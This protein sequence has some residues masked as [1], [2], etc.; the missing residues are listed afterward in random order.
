MASST[1]SMM[2]TWGAS[3][4]FYRVI[5]GLLFHAIS[6]VAGNQ[7]H[8]PVGP[9]VFIEASHHLGG[10]GHSACGRW[11]RESPDRP[12]GSHPATSLC[13]ARHGRP[14]VHG[15]GVEQH[16]SVRHAAEP[17]ADTWQNCRRNT[18]GAALVQGNGE[19]CQI[20]NRSN[21]CS[22]R[23][24][25]VALSNDGE[26]QSDSAPRSGLL[27]ATR[28]DSFGSRVTTTSDS[29]CSAGGALG[30]LSADPQRR[31]TMAIAV[32]WLDA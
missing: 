12:I 32:V 3:H 31:P 20:W 27:R 5:C 6:L 30:S 17:T 18:W 11:R 1:S 21:S 13:R 19:P 29:S 26:R 2:G 25:R 16:Q 10:G 22:T 14:E 24:T 23:N 28:A 8:T 4:F 7:R 15:S 9:P